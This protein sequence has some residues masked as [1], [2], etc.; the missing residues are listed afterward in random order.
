MAYAHR[1]SEEVVLR[2]ADQRGGGGVGR[3]PFQTTDEDDRRRLV[4]LALH[5][6]GRRGDLVGK[7]GLGDFELAPKE[8]GVAAPVDDRRQ[9]GSA[10][11]DADRA[12][13]ERPAKAV[14][15]DDRDALPGLVDELAAQRL[16]R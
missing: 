4:G 12:A 15:D 1:S 10:E 9:P 16:R 5:E 14:A 3:R 7:P 2:R 11:R 13:A 6:R 8:V